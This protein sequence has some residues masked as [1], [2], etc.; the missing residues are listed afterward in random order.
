MASSIISVKRVR[1]LLGTFVEIEL[2]AAVK[3]SRLQRWITLGFQAIEQIDQLMSAHRPDSDIRRLNRKPSGRRIRLHPLTTRVLAAAKRLHDKSEG[4]FDI[5]N[6]KGELDLG[7]IAKGF[8]VD[9]AVTCIRRTA[10]G[11]QLQGCVNAGG[12]LRVWGTTPQ[13]LAIRL[14]S[15]T[16]SRAKSFE[17]VEAA[18]AT[19][20]PRQSDSSR[21]TK[22]SFW[23]SR[24]GASHQRP[25][26]VTVFAD[27]CMA[28]D[29][30]T[31][32]VLLG[33]PEIAKRCLS[34]YKAHA[35]IEHLHHRD[36]L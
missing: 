1:P 20:A 24:A 23:T 18:V 11:I 17:A 14:G 4:V 19:T 29:A 5:H 6:P 31:K 16:R 8:A 33:K 10:R 21:Y 13:R 2:R 30:L 9:Q 3:E 12:D 34:A 32:V 25:V 26:T 22:A 36:F 28:A 7:G 15:S 35:V 27:D